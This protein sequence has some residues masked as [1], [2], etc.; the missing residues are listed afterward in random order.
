MCRSKLQRIQAQLPQDIQISVGND[1]SR[2]IR[3]SFEDIKLHLILGGLL[4]S[5]VVFLFIRNLRVTFIA[6]LAIPTSIIGTFTFMKI[7][8]FTLNNMTM[9][10]L[11]LATGIVIDDAIVVLEN[12]FRYVEEKG[13]TPKEAAA[14]AT[15]EIGLRGHGDDAVAGRH[16]RAGGVH[17]RPDRALLLQ[18]RPDVG[19]RDPALDVRVVHADAGAVRDVDE[20]R[21][22]QV[23]SLD[24]QG[25]AA[26]TRRWTRVYG[27]MLVWSLHHRPAMMA[28]AGAVVLSAAFLL[29]VCRQGAR[30]RRR[31]GR[32]QRQRAAA[33]RHELPAHRGV[34]QADR[35]RRPGAA[36]AA[37]R[38]AER[39]LRVRELQHH[40]G[41]A[42]R[43]DRSRSRS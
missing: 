34:H 20:A 31:P 42:R 6:A 25:R 19:G 27:R 43:A 29:S 7:A 5:I 2:F 22:H 17:D 33:A 24:D 14:D 18:L 23:R 40:D 28:I 39:Q 36:G 30:P 13:V 32:V 1:Q 38:D 41:A 21:G 3:R 8:G 35:K 26:S 15:R 11:S 10:A 16:L 12:I 4:A 9:L 37:A